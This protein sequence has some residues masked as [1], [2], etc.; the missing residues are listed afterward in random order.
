[1]MIGSFLF[2]HD[3]AL[4]GVSEWNISITMRHFAEDYSIAI[5]VPLR[6]QLT[7]IMPNDILSNVSGTAKYQN[8]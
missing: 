6:L 7:V 5:H 2:L 8:I 4:I 3:E 1:M